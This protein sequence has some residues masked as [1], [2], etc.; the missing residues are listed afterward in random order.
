MNFKDFVQVVLY[1]NMSLGHTHDAAK[2][3][4]LS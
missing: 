4:L 3:V 1:S 2:V